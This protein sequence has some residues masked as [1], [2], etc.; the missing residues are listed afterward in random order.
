MMGWL[1]C[2]L[3]A[4]RDAVR[5]EAR[6]TTEQSRHIILHAA[7]R[8]ATQRNATLFKSNTMRLAILDDY[9]AI[10]QTIVDWRQVPGLSVVSYR[11]HVYDE[12]ELIERLRGFD[13]V[14]RIRER[15]AFSGELLEQ[16]PQLKL[17]R[18]TGMRNARSID[19]PACQRL[20]ITVCTTNAMHQTTVELTWALILNL[21]RR[22]P[23]ETQSV[24]AGGWQRGVGVGL[25]GR[26]LG[27]LG[28]GNM[29]KPVAAIGRLFGMDVIAWSP[30]L[31]QERCDPYGVRCVSK[32]TLFD[33][34]D[35]VTVHMPA[36]DR[37]VGIVSRTDIESMK[38]DA[39]FVNT[40]RAELIDESALIEAL[41]ARRIAGAGLDVYSVEPLPQDHPFRWLPN[42]IATPHIGFV[43]DQNMQ[44]FFQTSLTNLKAFMSGNPVNVISH[45]HPLLADSQLALQGH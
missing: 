40:A 24:A 25:A 45:A 41:E 17:I 7:L 2:F 19:L 4:G 15:T 35:V 6:H 5:Q 38:P 31:T 3:K 22:L 34:S 16:L 20:G 33:S 11:D 32:Q 8:N 28:L 14:M 23:Q 26:T 1:V 36:S 10:S 27:I 13:A 18:A 44:E 9:Q 39:Y 12:R 43:T 21:F 30:N 37:T 42:V 29:G